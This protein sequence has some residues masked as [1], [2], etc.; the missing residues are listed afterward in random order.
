MRIY[1]DYFHLSSNLYLAVTFLSFVSFSVSLAVLLFPFSF[2]FIMSAYPCVLP[3]NFVSP[4]TA[5]SLFPEPTLVSLFSSRFLLQL[6]ASFSAVLPRLS[7]SFSHCRSCP[8]FIS[9]SSIM[10]F[11][12]LFMLSTM[13]CTLFIPSSYYHFVSLF[14]SF[15]C[16]ILCSSSFSLFCFLIVAFTCF[17][18]HSS[19]F[20]SLSFLAAYITLATPTLFTFIDLHFLPCYFRFVT[21]SYPT[22]NIS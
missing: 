17:H 3:I 11:P 12:V 10:S 6:L 9:A 22:P 20:L 19:V 14:C 8:Y 5:C 18:I 7:I 15:L 1:H 13:A 4:V 16:F 21:S 2:P